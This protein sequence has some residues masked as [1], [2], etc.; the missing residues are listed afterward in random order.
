MRTGSNGNHARVTTN[1]STITA[2]GSSRLA[3]RE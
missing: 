3:R 1:A 2:S